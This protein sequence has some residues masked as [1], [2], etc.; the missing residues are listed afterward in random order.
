MARSEVQRLAKHYRACNIEHYGECSRT[1]VTRYRE[2]LVQGLTARFRKMAYD[3]EK[4][5]EETALALS[6]RSG[7]AQQARDKAYPDIGIY[8]GGGG[9]SMQGRHDAKK[10]NIHTGLRGG[11]AA[12]QLR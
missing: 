7:R 4:H 2:G 8:S 3:D 11:E 10:I 5:S 6:S 9:G 12:K 1:K